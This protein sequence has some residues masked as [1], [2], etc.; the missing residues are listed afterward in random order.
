[1]NFSPTKSGR[2]TELDVLDAVTR[3]IKKDVKGIQITGDECRIRLGNDEAKQLLKKQKL[4]I[5]DRSIS[6]MLIRIPRVSQLN[7]LLWS[8]M[9]W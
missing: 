6:M 9:T 4:I 8:L 3:I 5:N 1:M 2:T 7:K